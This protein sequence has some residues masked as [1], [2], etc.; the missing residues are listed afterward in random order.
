MK[1][2]LILLL[3]VL[4]IA[5]PLAACKD[6]NNPGIPPAASVDDSDN[7]QM[8]DF[9]PLPDGTYGVGIGKA[10]YLNS[11]VIPE[12]YNGKAVTRMVG[13]SWSD[14]L[15]S[16]TIP[17]SITYI[18]S[19]GNNLRLVEVINHSSL[20]ITTTSY[21]L[22]ALEVH[23]GE[24]KLVEKDGYLFYTFDNVNYLL[25]YS[26]NDTEITLP[27]DYNGQKYEIYKNAFYNN[28]T[29]TS[30]II[31]DN[32][33]GIGECAF[34]NCSSLTSITLGNGVTS[35]G[36]CAFSLC[37]SLASIKY[38]GTEEQWGNITKDSIGYDGTITYNYTG[39]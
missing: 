19:L 35:M 7:P 27:S 14:A 39:E 34:Y 18:Q 33:T 32:V 15:A 26:G 37:D 11:I 20:E 30:V 23:T 3:C 2:I 28:D 6:K 17:K 22:D 21:G 16:I 9:F 8:L 31:P 5:V 13:D 38:K 4:L 1:K 10:I 25:G 12:T 29:I 24:S 36:N